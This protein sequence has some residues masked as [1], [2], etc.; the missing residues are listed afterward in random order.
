M[1]PSDLEM[2]AKLDELASM[3]ALFVLGLKEHT[4][5]AKLQCRIV[6]WTESSSSNEML[7]YARILA[8]FSYGLHAMGPADLEP[9]AA[10]LLSIASN[11]VDQVAKA[12]ANA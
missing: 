5:K 3:D 12:R 11:L 2:R 10:Q 1:I 8:A 4:D 7:Y 9:K 6:G